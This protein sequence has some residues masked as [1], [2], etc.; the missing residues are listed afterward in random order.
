ME[1][2]SRRQRVFAIGIASALLL[3][4]LFG[5][6][7]LYEPGGLSVMQRI[8]QSG[9]LLVATRVGPATYHAGAAGPDGFEYTLARRFA[10]DHGLDIEFV[11]PR[12]LAALLDATERGTV[13]L[14]AAGLSDTPQRRRR[15]RF[16]DPYRQTGEQVVYRRGSRRPRSMDEIGPGELHVIAHSAHEETLHRLRRSG[17]PQLSWQR[18]TNPDSLALLAAIDQGSIRYAMTD[19]AE[20]DLGRRLYRHAAA[21]FNLSAPRPIAWAMSPSGDSSLQDAVNAFFRRLEDNGDLQRLRARYFGHRGR[22]NFVDTREFWR[23]VRDRLPGL[24]DHFEQAAELTGIDWRLLAAIGYQESHWRSDA[25]SPTGVRG[26]MMLTRATARQ[27][28][29]DDRVDPVQSI[30]GGAKYLRR[31]ERRIPERV[32]EPDRLWLTLAG[33]N[34]GFGHLEDA[35]MLTERDGADPD[36]WLEVKQRL[37]LLAQKEYYRSLRYGFARGQ[38]PVDYV[39]NIRNYYEM[40]VWF[41]TSNQ[42]VR[43]R[44]LSAGDDQPGSDPEPPPAQPRQG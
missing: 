22:L 12:S 42:A 27:L 26:V 20:L 44:L 25:V 33:Y 7:V 1:L 30:I 19:S 16:S 39:D 34:V 29:I 37:P 14:A 6:H 23:N 43:D 38:E 10:Q 31:I 28:G 41:T 35:R 9:R 18:Q 40:L 21:A 32:S 36:L 15:L 3:G 13:H 2:A 24:R 8:Q 17:L 4:G 5:I 11:F